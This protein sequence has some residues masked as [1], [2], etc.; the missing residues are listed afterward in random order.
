MTPDS[1]VVRVRRWG[2]LGMLEGDTTTEPISRDDAEVI[3]LRQLQTL[4]P[5][6]MAEITIARG[7]EP[8]LPPLPETVAKLPAFHVR[9]RK[10]EL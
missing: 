9:A 6:D 7:T 2:A 10:A 1:Y 8:L 3:V 5:A 4:C